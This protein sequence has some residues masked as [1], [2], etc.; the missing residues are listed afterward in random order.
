MFGGHIV[1]YSRA[2][3]VALSAISGHGVDPVDPPVNVCED[4]KPLI[5]QNSPVRNSVCYNQEN[6]FKC[7][8][9]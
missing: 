3:V 6:R 9:T 2:C 1:R 8:F 4:E 7:C 5:N